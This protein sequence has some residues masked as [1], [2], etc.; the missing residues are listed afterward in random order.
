MLTRQIPFKRG[1]TVEAVNI[2][3][4]REI[5]EALTQL[6]IPYP[7]RVIVLVGGA[8]GIG[9]WDK[10]PMSKAIR[11]IARL[12]EETQSVVVDGGTQ[13]GIMAEIGKQR[14]QYRFSFPLVGVV[15]DN[16]LLKEE[17][18]SILDPNHTHFFLVPGEDWG[19]ESAWIS[20]IATAVAGD[21][22]SITVLVNGGNISKTD[23]GYSLLENRP[24]FV[25]RGTGRMADE[26]T[27]GEK[28]LAINITEKADDI[29]EFLKTR[30]TDV[31]L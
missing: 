30:L 13:A 17:P 2:T 27:L 25:M 10:F 19:D 18:Q 9:W 6:G 4:D 28:I 1:A 7:N 29:R 12:A 3:E 14:K 24:A 11:I 31:Q 8:G 21:Q 20:K 16:L 23:V 5:P 26:I 15:F 22:K